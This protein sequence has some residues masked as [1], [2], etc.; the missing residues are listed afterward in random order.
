MFRIPHNFIF[1]RLVSLKELKFKSWSNQD[2]TTLYK[3][4]WDTHDSKKLKRHENGI[5]NVGHLK[6]FLLFRYF[7]NPTKVS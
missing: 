4:D 2:T 7:Q 1:P 6:I 5:E 3:L